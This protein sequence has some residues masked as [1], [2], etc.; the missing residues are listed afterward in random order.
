MMTTTMLWCSAH[1]PTQEQV[2]RGEKGRVILKDHSKDDG[3]N[4]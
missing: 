2:K 3:E 1:Q 4:I